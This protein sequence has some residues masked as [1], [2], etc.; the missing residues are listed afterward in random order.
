[1]GTRD[2][3][4]VKGGELTFAERFWKCYTSRQYLM[5]MRLQLINCNEFLILQPYAGESAH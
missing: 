2:M 5:G 4:K 3:Q 1:M